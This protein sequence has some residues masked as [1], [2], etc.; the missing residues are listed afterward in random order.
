MKHTSLNLLHKELQAKMTEFAGYEMPLYYLSIIKEHLN[1]RNKVGIFDVSH[2]GDIIVSGADAEDYLFYLFSTNIKNMKQGQARYTCFLNEK[3]L[4]IDDTIVTKLEDDK[5]LV[6][7]NAANIDKILNWM[8]K[9]TKKFD[10]EII[11]LSEKISCIAL[12]GPFSANLIKQLFDVDL[13]SFE[14][15]YQTYDHESQTNEIFNKENT[16]LLSKT[17]YT[18]EKGY[19]IIIS[20]S[21]AE[22]LWGKL[23]EIG[24]EY[25]IMPCGLGSRD[26]LRMEKGYLL[27]GQ[28][29]KEDRTP[30]EAGISWTISWEH[31]FIGKNAILNKKPEEIFRGFIMQE[32]GFPRHGCEIYN[33]NEKVGIITSGGISPVLNCGIGLGY[34]KKE[35]AETG[36]IVEIDIRGKRKKIKVS[37]PK[38]V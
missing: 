26:T 3:G 11:N 25:E 30:V 22:K 33:G 14:V 32:N 1:V 9:N 38:M 15:S 37:K 17:G 8:K 7:P 27:S 18:G 23:M 36:N 6:V 35:N 12:Q 20:N 16:I 5:F 19:E 13:K 31:E 29:F 34:I 4:M 10:V 21:G 24:K 28:D 2:M